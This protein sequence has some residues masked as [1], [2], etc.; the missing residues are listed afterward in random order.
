MTATY[1]AAMMDAEAAAK[2]LLAAGANRATKNGEGKTAYELAKARN[3]SVEPLLRPKQKQK[4]K[5]KTK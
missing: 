4:P 1:Q 2:L 5:T 3:N